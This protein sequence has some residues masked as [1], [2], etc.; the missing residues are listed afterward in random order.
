MIMNIILNMK[1]SND[2]ASSSS[3]TNLGRRLEAGGVFFLKSF[4]VNC[5]LKVFEAATE[6]KNFKTLQ[7]DTA[8]LNEENKAGHQQFR[9][10]RETYQR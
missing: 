4:D 5:F 8:R 6:K 3:L 9:H 1:Y 2:N 10:N 7:E